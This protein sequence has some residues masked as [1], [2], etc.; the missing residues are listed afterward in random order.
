MTSGERLR[1]EGNYYVRGESGSPARPV[2]EE[3]DLDL[4]LDKE[5]PE[6]PG[7]GQE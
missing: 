6:I 1:E 5:K 3:E 7:N 2:W 4:T